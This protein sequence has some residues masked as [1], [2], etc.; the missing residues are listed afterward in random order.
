MTK[1][2]IT[3]QSASADPF[4]PGEI[5]RRLEAANVHRLQKQAQLDGPTALLPACCATCWYV[6]RYG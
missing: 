3:Q 4:V 6:W 2:E 5:A 1:P